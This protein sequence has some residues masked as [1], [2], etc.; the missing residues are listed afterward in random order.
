MYCFEDDKMVVS[1]DKGRQVIVIY[2]SWKEVWN[3]KY[4]DKLF[5]FSETC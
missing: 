5:N 4:D 3:E 2:I 1:T